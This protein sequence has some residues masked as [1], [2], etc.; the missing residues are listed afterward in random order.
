MEFIIYISPVRMYGKPDVGIGV[1]EVVVQ[2]VKR[3]VNH[4]ASID[5]D[6]N[7]RVGELEGVVAHVVQNPD[8]ILDSFEAG[9]FRNVVDIPCFALQFLVVGYQQVMDIW[10]RVFDFPDG[11]I[12][13]KDALDN[14]V[15][16]HFT[17][18][19]DFLCRLTFWW[20]VCGT[21]QTPQ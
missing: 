19:L 15:L 5:I 16:V 14:S 10:L 6:G 7:H 11:F 13:V 18:R 4:H 3:L 17:R 1:H 8:D 12:I 2:L 20:C 9:I 21:Y